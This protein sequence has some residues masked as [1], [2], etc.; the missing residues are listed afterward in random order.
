MKKKDN[1]TDLT[2][3]EPGT[4][5][6]K[7]AGFVRDSEGN[8]VQLNF[9]PYKKKISMKRLNRVISNLNKKK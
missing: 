8:L 1:L 6:E 4:T 5:L 9:K 3:N 2:N 7:P